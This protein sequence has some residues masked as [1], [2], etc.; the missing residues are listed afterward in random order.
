MFRQNHL[1]GMQ[2]IA[3]LNDGYGLDVA[4]VAVGDRVSGT[5]SDFARINNALYVFNIDIV[6]RGE[7]GVLVPEIDIVYVVEDV[8]RAVAVAADYLVSE[9]N[10]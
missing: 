4:S 9:I 10:Q 6:G 2:M 3:A 7:A 1:L 8:W 5:S